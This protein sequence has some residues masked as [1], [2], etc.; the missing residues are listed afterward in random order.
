MAIWGDVLRASLPDLRIF[1]QDAVGGAI[2]RPKKLNAASEI[3]EPA[4][5]RV[6]YTIMGDRVFGSMCL[7]NNLEWDAPIPITA[8]Q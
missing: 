4:V 2:P 8:L 1:P 7:N 5:L 6:A 3:I